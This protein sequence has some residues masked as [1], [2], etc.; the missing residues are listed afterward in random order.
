[1]RRKNQNHYN[2]TLYRID[3]IFRHSGAGPE[4]S[5]QITGKEIQNTYGHGYDKV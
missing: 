4:Y 3:S 1:M 5:D 2:R